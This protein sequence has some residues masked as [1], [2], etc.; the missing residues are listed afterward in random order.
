MIEWLEFQLLNLRGINLNYELNDI[1]DKVREVG[2]SKR[3]SRANFY[4][5]F[6]IFTVALLSELYFGA[7]A[8]FFKKED[9]SIHTV[10]HVVISKVIDNNKLLVSTVRPKDNLTRIFKR[11]GIAITPK[12]A[13][14]ILALK[15]AGP[16][17]ELQV[18]KKVN[19]IVD[20]VSV[21][22]KQLVYAINELDTLIVAPHNDGWSAQVKHIEPVINL[23]YA[24]ATINGSLYT[25]ASHEGISHKM[26]TKMANIF[27]GKKVNFK[28]MQKGDRFALFYKEY[29]VDGKKIKE[30][31]IVAAEITHKDQSYRMIGFTDSKGITDYYTP[32]GYNSK[33]PIRRLPL[34]NYKR[35]S[36][37]FSLNRHHPILDITRPHWGVDF[38]ASYGTPIT[39]TCNGRV[40]FVGFK[41]EHGRTII[42]NHGVYS[43]VYAHLSKYSSKVQ[44]GGYVKQG[45]IIGFVGSSGLAAGPHLHYEVKVRGVHHDPLKIKLP[46]GEMIAPEYRGKFMALSKRVSAQLDLRNAEHGLLAMNKVTDPKL[47]RKLIWY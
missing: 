27:S 41:G 28:K 22:L 40:K 12:E 31:E 35:I 10:S 45:Q 21:K 46:E 43:T 42:V 18:G 4:V 15:Q 37:R 38:S 1:Y 47:W 29:I 5:I 16:L 26:V 13:K 9:G 17:R 30:D 19:L 8:I 6:A 44:E 25:A 32:E 20:P 11:L 14:A 24:S 2:F 33:P 39:A 3:T 23:K 7:K 36:S 34:T